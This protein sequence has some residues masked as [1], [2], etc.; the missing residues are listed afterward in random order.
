[1]QPT[2]KLVQFLQEQ[3][4]TTTHFMIGMNILQNPQQ[5]QTAFNAGHDI[6]VHTWTHPRMTTLSNLDVL[7][8]VSDS[9]MLA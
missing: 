6:A 4:K 2:T 7:G 8:Q 1:M 9:E 3:G 5:F